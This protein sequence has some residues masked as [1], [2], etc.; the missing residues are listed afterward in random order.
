MTIG[1]KKGELVKGIRDCSEDRVGVFE[2]GVVS[3]ASS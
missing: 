2:W 1:L 3:W